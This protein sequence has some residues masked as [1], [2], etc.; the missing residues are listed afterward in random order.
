MNNIRIM[1]VTIKRFRGFPDEVTIPF[2]SG[3]TVIYA[4]NG[5]GK[6]TICQAVEWLFT[7][8]IADI[9]DSAYTC[10]WGVGEKSVSA[11]CLIDGKKQTFSR[12]DK[13]I[14]VSDGEGQIK[15]LTEKAL[16]EMIT[17]VEVGTGHTTSIN[18]SKREWFRHSRWL[19]SNSLSM[20]VD[21]AAAEQRRQ[22]FA[23]ILGYGH[24]SNQQ[25]QV[26]DYIRN[27]PSIQSEQRQLEETR[28]FKDS[29]FTKF[30]GKEN[31]ETIV[32]KN[33]NKLITQLNL[34]SGDLSTVD[35]LPLIKEALNKREIAITNNT[36]IVTQLM[37]RWDAAIHYSDEKNAIQKRK[38]IL[39][40]DL[41]NAEEKI[42]ALRKKNG[43]LRE[44][45][46]HHNEQYNTLMSL[47]AVFPDS[48]PLINYLHTLTGDDIYG[49]SAN[50]VFALIPESKLDN[51]TLLSR[52]H[53]LRA[54][55]DVMAENTFA[56]EHRKEWE[57]F[58]SAAPSEETLLELETDIHQ[59]EESIALQTSQLE[60]LT[61]VTEQLFMLGKTYTDKAQSSCCPLC[62]HDWEEREHLV[63]AIVKTGSLF[64]PQLKI[65][66]DNLRLSRLALET[67]KSEQVKLLAQH[68]QKIQL[69]N[70]INAADFN[71]MKCVEQFSLDSWLP[72]YRPAYIRTDLIEMSLARLIHAERLSE[73]YDSLER[74]YQ[75]VG[76][77]A[78]ATTDSF[79]QQVAAVQSLLPSYCDSHKHQITLI[80]HQLSTQIALENIQQGAIQ[81]LILELKGEEQKLANITY[82]QQEFSSYWSQLFRDDSVNKSILVRFQESLTS[83]RDVLNSLIDLYNESRLGLESME[84]SKTIKSLESQMLRLEDSI[85]KQLKRRYTA[86]Q[87][88]SELTSEIENRTSETIDSLMLPASELFSR[89]HANE[90][91]QG[92]N[93]VNKGNFNWCAITGEVVRDGE[94]PLITENFFSQGQRQDL[95]LSLY[96]SRARALGGTFFLDEPV[97]HLDDLNRVAM[98]DIFRMMCLAEKGMNLILTTASD[99]LRRH[100][101]QKFSAIQQNGDPLLTVITLKGNPKEGVGINIS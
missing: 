56:N 59:M 6:S 7:G 31:Q 9:S 100:L 63:D 78:L 75:L 53:G 43:E 64:D 13:G 25:K 47:Q 89:M 87:A 38:D 91:Y 41:K 49:F 81:T 33:I 65:L 99:P 30:S 96:L 82:L 12:S 2:N 93:V 22:I 76:E 73:I 8:E 68:A 95:A 90:V 21:D 24:L 94:V 58:I 45:L 62:S 72:E 66:D 44:E 40:G 79:L 60:N 92:F 69:R 70:Q 29:L 35:R 88:L 97:A 34:P 17:P 37:S 11:I 52:R 5:T 20:L 71:T 15:R 1:S 80:E 18:R 48:Q 19:Y 83:D 54:L 84:E 77:E 32:V 61:N 55:L 42:Q 39:A 85:S 74:V 67:K 101:R 4:A 27:L 51:N 10:H 14:Y 50:S 98:T 86:E 46:K 36:K 3:L 16:L 26:Q 57:D 28:A 23:N